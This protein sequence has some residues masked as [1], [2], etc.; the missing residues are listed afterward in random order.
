M[1]RKFQDLPLV[2]ATLVII[3][4]IVFLVSIFT[5]GLLYNLGG[6]HRTSIV[7]QHEYGRLFWAMFLH[8]DTTHLFNNMVILFFLGSMLERETGHISFAILYFLAGIG[9][10]VVSLL[11]KIATGSNTISVGASGAVFGLDGLVLALVLFSR[12]FRQT[13]TPMRVILM[14]VLSLYDGFM[15]DYVDNAAHV[16]GLVVGFLAGVVF[17]LARDMCNKR[18]FR[19]E[20]QI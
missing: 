10:N 1:L 9:G 8:V 15:V 11:N 20:V 16:G 12:D 18:K 4:V 13:V 5:G 14:I 17:V 7:I 3:N 19:R 2:S 6:V